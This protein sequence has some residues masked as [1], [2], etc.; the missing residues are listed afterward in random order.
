MW[1][2]KNKE[3]CFVWTGNECVLYDVLEVWNCIQRFKYVWNERHPAIALKLLMEN[4][5]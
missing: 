1:I 3:T 5:I 4:R 2:D